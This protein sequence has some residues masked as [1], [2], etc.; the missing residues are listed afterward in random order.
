ML[1]PVF[2][3]WKLVWCRVFCCW[4]HVHVPPG[5]AKQAVC[6]HIN[7]T[8]LASSYASCYN[9]SQETFHQSQCDSLSP[10]SLTGTQPRCL[11]PIAPSHTVLQEAQKEPEWE[12][13]QSKPNRQYTDLQGIYVSDMP[14]G[15]E[16]HNWTDGS[17][18]YGEWREGQP[19][20]RGIFV[21]Q[22]GQY[23]TW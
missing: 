7:I 9:E 22:S 1:G 15:E 11:P 21:S 13:V 18:Y 5:Q 8:H 17:E 12:P 10:S 4:L 3:V 23:Q 16:H 14:D 6:H 20:G 2:H 19:S